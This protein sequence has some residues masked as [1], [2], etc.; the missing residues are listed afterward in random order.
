M[1]SFRVGIDVGG[2]FTDL[3]ASDEE[4]GDLVNIKIP[5]TPTRPADG[6]VECLREF[7]R[8]RKTEDI[9]ILTHATTIASNAMLGQIGLELPKTG[10][11]TTKGFKD[12]LEIGRQR[13]HQ[14]Y[15]L[16]I[17]RP[18]T[19]VPRE[20]RF[21]VEERIGTDGEVLRRLDTHALRLVTNVLKREHV[22]SIAI[23]FLN[24]Y[25]NPK[26]E[27]EAAR[28]VRNTCQD[29]FLAVSSEVCSEYREYERIS[30]AVVNACL[31]PIV[32][33][34]VSELTERIGNL[35][36][37]AKLYVLQSSGGIASPAVIVK[38]PASIVESG[39][40]A[41]V[42]AAAFYGKMLGIENILSFDM[43]GTTAKAGI[44]RSYSPET[45]TE[46]EV[47]G[48]VHSGRITKGSGYPVRFPFIDLAECSA[49]GGTIA[50]VDAGGALRIGPTS[51]GARP[52]PAC[53][54]L[55]G[56]DPTI[57]DANL[58]LGRLNPEHI[59]GGQMKVYS[60]MARKS[61]EEKICGRTGLKL[62]EAA[63]GIVKIAISDMAKILRIVS[64]ERGH[65]PRLHVLVAFGGAGPMHA[66]AMAED[67][68]IPKVVVVVNP[69]LFSALG[70]LASDFTHHLLRTLLKKATDVDVNR[71][72]GLFD[73]LEAEARGTLEAEKIPADQAM[74][75][76]QF[77]A[78]YFGQAYELS[79]PAARPFDHDALTRVIQSFHQKHRSVYG[80]AAESEMVELVGARI[81]AIGTVAKPKLRARALGEPSPPGNALLGP[82][83]VFFEECDDYLRCP[84]YVREKLQPGNQIK[85]PAVIEQYDATTVV[86]PSWSAHIDE[87]GGIVLERR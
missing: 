2:T 30:T 24:A 1:A 82:R 14:L 86:Y 84:V 50:W 25:A 33:T 10:L 3:V 4:T 54:R 39:P 58:V 79:V 40:A 44:I 8:S 68:H 83:D 36:I 71:V 9:S 77:D 73:E 74:F 22:K 45:V 28:I 7:L 38:K 16:F 12:V 13:R 43:G 70:L 69:G 62:V 46:Y 15:N 23:G 87:Y 21:V 55:G 67:L 17:E 63:A 48:R 76:R 41:G 49:G 34:Y 75:L 60:D 85:G 78:R 65:D 27:K 31:M 35:G 32:S 18:R 51:A 53:Y 66:C 37:H 5:T 57:T 64:I 47:G 19:L 26:H 20:Y 6:V 56:E 11:I 59:L 29:A 81:I 61:I 72:D 42:I 80:Y 52:G